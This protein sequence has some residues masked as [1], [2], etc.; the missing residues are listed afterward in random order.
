MRRTNGSHVSTGNL[1]SAVKRGN[2]SI[3]LESIHHSPSIN[4]NFAS[5]SHRLFRHCQLNFLP[6]GQ[7]CF[8]SFISRS[9]QFRFAFFPNKI[10]IGGRGGGIESKEMEKFQNC[11]FEKKRERDEIPGEEC[12]SST[13]ELKVIREGRRRRRRRS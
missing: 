1:L 9:H 13:D 3:A 4:C 5:F 8:C 7:H 2:K 11:N 6:S 10:F 12:E